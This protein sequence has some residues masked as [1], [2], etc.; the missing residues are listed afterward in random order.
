[1]EPRWAC[2]GAVAAPPTAKKSRQRRAPFAKASASLSV[3]SDGDATRILFRKK[4]PKLYRGR[5]EVYSWLRVHQAEVAEML[6]RG[7]LSWPMLAAEMVRVGV[8]GG[9]G[10]PPT[11]KAAARVWR[12]VCRDVEQAALANGPQK[13][14]YPSRIS[15]N[16]RPPVVPPSEASGA[17]GAANPPY[18]PDE[19]LARIRRIIAERSGRKA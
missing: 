14:K 17:Q 19:Q 6:A 11:S 16:W 13:R 4:R 8:K 12:R 3:M 9:R 5:G 7:E 2:D 15:P 1:M 10:E 18:D